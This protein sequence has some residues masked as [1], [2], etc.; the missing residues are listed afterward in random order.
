MLLEVR[1][2]QMR[3]PVPGFAGGYLRFCAEHLSDLAGCVERQNLDA[4]SRMARALRTNAHRLGLEE[5]SSLG[6]QMEDYCLGPDWNAIGSVCRSIS[7]TVLKLCDG[8][9]TPIAVEFE[10]DDHACTFEVEG[11]H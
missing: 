6:R 5:L 7:E 10:H 9:R 8:H 3:R 4:V 2:I 1:E 11:A